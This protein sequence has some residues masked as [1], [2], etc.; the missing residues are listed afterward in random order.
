[1]VSLLWPRYRHA[2]L[3]ERLDK[4]EG[5]P[6]YFKIMWSI[7]RVRRRH[8]GIASGAFGPP[9]HSA[10]I[11]TFRSFKNM[12]LI[13]DFGKRNRTQVVTDACKQYGGFYLGSI[14][15]RRRSWAGIASRMC[16]LLNIL[17]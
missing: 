11:P 15:G 10:W 16:A 5:L 1:V 6:D 8:R 2:K 14:G 4:G 9:P 17:N 13:G 3:K 12:G 7:M